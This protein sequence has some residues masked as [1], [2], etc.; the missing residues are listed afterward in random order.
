[1]SGGLWLSGGWGRPPL[2]SV[3]R[4]LEAHTV[5]VFLCISSER[6]MVGGGHVEC[7][8]TSL[9]LKCDIQER[10]LDPAL[11]GATLAQQMVYVVSDLPHTLL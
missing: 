8:V 7:E 5:V 1:M 10:I 9:V 4:T 11:F 2:T 6:A 3:G